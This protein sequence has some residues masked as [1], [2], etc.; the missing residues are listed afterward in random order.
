MAMASERERD[1]GSELAWLAFRYVAGEM[2][3]EEAEAFEGRLDQDQQAREAVARVV[4]LAGAVAAQAPQAATT[5]PFRRR[6]T[7]RT[8]VAAATMAAAA[9]LAWLAIHTGGPAPVPLGPRDATRMAPI[10]TVALTWS[11]LDQ[12]RAADKGDSSALV[13][14]NQELPAVAESEDLSV[15]DPGLPPWLVDAAALAGR[16]EHAGQPAKDL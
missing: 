16:P 1:D 12:E 4:E 7:I 6:A 14:W 8:F 5:L 10:A 11:T 2:T 9:C 15:S 3:V 13:A